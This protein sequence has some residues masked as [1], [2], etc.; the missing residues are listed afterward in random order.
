MTS[1]QQHHRAVA[2]SQ[3]R[4]G[5]TI[6]RRCAVCA[7]EIVGIARRRFCSA[8]CRLRASRHRRAGR[9]PAQTGR[10][11]EQIRRAPALNQAMIDRLARRR[12]ANALLGWSGGPDAAELVRQARADRSVDPPQNRTGVEP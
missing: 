11:A 8:A 6:V 5:Q 9:S 12:D 7:T 3:A 2:R 1:K 10:I 4:S